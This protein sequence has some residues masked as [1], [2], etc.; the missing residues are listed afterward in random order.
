MRKILPL[1]A[2]L[3]AGLILGSPFSHAASNLVFCSEGSPAGFDPA[4]Y[5]TGT[6]YDATSVTL[7]NRLVQF[8]RGGTRAIPALAE[9]WDIGDDGKTYT[10]HL[11]KGV[12][13]HSTDYFK[14]TREF[15]ADDVLFTFQ[16]MLDKNHPFRKA[17]PTEFPYFTDMGLDKNIARVEKL[18]EHRVKFTLNEVDAAFIQNLAMDVASIQS[19]EYAGQLLEAGKPQ[20]INQK[21]IGTGP[22]ILSR[23]QKDAQIRFKG[24]KDYWKPEDVKIDNLIFSINTDAAV[25]AQKLKAGEC[26]I[27][28]NPRPADLKALQEAAN[29]KVPSQPGFNLGYIAYNVTHK[30][31]D[32]LEVRQALDMAVNKQAIID[33][34][35]Q[36]AGQL[37][38]NGMPPTQWSYDET[39]KDAPFDPAKARELLKKAGVAEG[40]EITLWAMPV[41]RPYNPNAKLMAEMIQADW[42]KIGIKAR[43]VSY[44]WGEYIKRAHAGEH[45]AM[46]FGWTGDNGDPDNWLATLYGCDSINGNNVS[47]WCDAAYDKLVKAAK[48]VSDQ[49]KRSELYKQAQ[50]ILKEQVPITPIAHSTVYQPMNKSVHDFKISPFSRNAFYGVANTSPDADA[51]PVVKRPG[52]RR[53]ARPVLHFFAFPARVPERR[54]ARS[55]RSAR[56]AVFDR[57]AQARAK[58]A[59][60]WWVKQ[61]P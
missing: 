12:K 47:K 36:G 34:V 4:Q 3:A 29:L 60:T 20:Q 11:R 16:R 45:D 58:P 39:I 43:I 49:D 23:Y 52:R 55:A 42:A 37:A 44:E 8:E 19:A 40:T 32:Q 61:V 27:T 56:L 24:N 30:P 28:L 10:F 15:N 7:F 21:P 18:D 51:T 5:T 26:Q 33:A 14:P 6:D 46:L 17:Y 35:Y 41:Q 2:W 53:T 13:F 54:C 31:F 9:S 38:V 50:H 59:Q 48:R 25:R 57:R 1:R 22:F